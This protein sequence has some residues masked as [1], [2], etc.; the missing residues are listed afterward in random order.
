MSTKVRKPLVGKK[1]VKS[2]LVNKAYTVGSPESQP[3]APTEPATKMLAGS[4][5]NIESEK[6]KVVVPQEGGDAIPAPVA[7]SPAYKAD[8]KALVDALWEVE[9]SDGDVADRRGELIH[10]IIVKLRADHYGKMPNGT[11]PFRKL[12]DEPGFP[13]G[14][15]QVRRIFNQ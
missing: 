12:A 5:I 3:V 10:P 6:T 11:D 15:K 8:I 4:P 14:P 9:G 7:G 2:S 13:L 1:V